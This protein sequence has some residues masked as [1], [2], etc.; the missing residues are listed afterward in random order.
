MVLAYV[1]YVAVLRTY[2]REAVPERE[3]RLAPTLAVAAFGTYGLI[4][5]VL[6][7]IYAISGN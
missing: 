3:R 4:V 5:V 1:A 6:W 2:P 7:V